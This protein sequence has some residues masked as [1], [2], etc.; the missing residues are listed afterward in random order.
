MPLQVESFDYGRV[1]LHQLYV[2]VVFPVFSGSDSWTWEAKWRNR[3]LQD[4]IGWWKL[5]RESSNEKDGPA[6]KTEHE[7]YQ[8]VG[9]VAVDGHRFVVCS[10]FGVHAFAQVQQ[11]LVVLLW[12]NP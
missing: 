12:R 9:T 3:D 2:K 8:V 4:M 10:A 7:N 1:A 6:Q 5:M 11:A